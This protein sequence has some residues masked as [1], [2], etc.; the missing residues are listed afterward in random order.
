MGYAAVKSASMVL[1]LWRAFSTEQVFGLGT[2]NNVE[3][4]IRI[5]DLILKDK[6]WTIIDTNYHK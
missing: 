2:E 4:S 5:R 1:I 6:L 3:I